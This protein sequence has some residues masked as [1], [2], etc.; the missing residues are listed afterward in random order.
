MTGSSY[1]V[2]EGV[3]APMASLVPCDPAANQPECTALTGAVMSSLEAISFSHPLAA[4][5]ERSPLTWRQ[6]PSRSVS[7]IPGVPDA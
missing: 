5:D 7:P 6:L 4:G 2:F 1:F 3:G